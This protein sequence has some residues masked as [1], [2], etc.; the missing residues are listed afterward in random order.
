MEPET[1][2]CVGGIQRLYHYLE[3]NRD[4]YDLILNA[5]NT[6]DLNLF[7]TLKFGPIEKAME[8]LNFTAI[9]NANPYGVIVTDELTAIKDQ[10]T[11]LKE[12]N[13]N[14]FIIAIGK[15]VQ[16][17]SCVMCLLGRL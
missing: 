2:N 11:K 8:L 7:A 16:L 1:T 13:Q 10:V 9:N 15:L 4:S 12:S 14:V 5:G 3:T 17:S 6:V